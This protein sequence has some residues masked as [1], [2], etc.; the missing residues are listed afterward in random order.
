MKFFVLIILLY[1]ISFQPVHA[2]NQTHLL[3]NLTDNQ[4]ISSNN[5]NQIRPIASI[6]KL[7]TA[8][9]VL[10][11]NM[12]MNEEIPYKGRI[13]RDS[14]VKR[15]ELLES[16]LIR[17]DNAAADSFANSFG[18]KEFIELMNQKARD[19]RMKDTFFDDASG[20]SK[21]NIST[22]KDLIILINYA[23]SHQ[24][25]SN[26]SSSKYFQVETKNKKKITYITVENTNNQLL[27]I[28]DFITLSKTGWTNP[29]GRCL[30][31]VI[32]KNEKKYAIIILGEKTPKDRFDRAKTLISMI[33]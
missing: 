13:W 27:R 25:I 20:L 11:S 4:I 10:E 7:M 23:Y 33:I 32:E 17:S 21:N 12:D 8:I 6:T 30:T 26:T 9:I 15:S 18:Y 19:L 24:K 3:I 28:F 5:E 29:A 2:N 22:A 1:N 31:L 16:L 14:K